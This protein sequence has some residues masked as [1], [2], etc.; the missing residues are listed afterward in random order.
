[1]LLTE[2]AARLLEALFGGP[3]RDV[4]RLGRD[5]EPHGICG[6]ALLISTQN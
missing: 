2:R 4:N 3:D 5:R 1:V 6:T